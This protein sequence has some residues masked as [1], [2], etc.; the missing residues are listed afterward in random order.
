MNRLKT[1][2]MVAV[3]A[4]VMAAVP[5]PAGAT[6]LEVKG[7]AQAGAVE[8]TASM[9]VAFSMLLQSTSGAFANTCT[10]SHFSTKTTSYTGATVGG[11]INTLT[12]TSCTTSPVVV[13]EAGSFSIE[14]IGT[15][16]NG[17]VRSSGTKTTV[18]S[19]LGGTLTCVTGEGVDLGTLRGVK[20]GSATLEIRAVINCGFLAPSVN[21]SASYTI[22]TS[23]VGVTG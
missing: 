13:D 18:P 4:G 22:T 3:M 10:A 6:T 5:S 16:T 21:W 20:E 2:A 11:P 7:V 12:Y 1:M 19:P 15:T 23:G 14:R 9:E 17:T 8:L